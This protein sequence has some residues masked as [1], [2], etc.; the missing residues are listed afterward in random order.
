MV[1]L[2]ALAMGAFGADVRLRDVIYSADEVY[3]L[4]AYGG[5][6]ID[7]EFEAGEHFLGMG[8]GDLQGLSFRAQENHLFIK[9]R[10]V[11]VHTDITV[12]TDRRVY[13]F[14]YVSIG[15]TPDETHADLVYALRFLYPPAPRKQGVVGGHSVSGAAR[16]SVASESA[17]NSVVGNINY[18]FC[19]TPLLQP[20]AAWD[21]GMQTHLRFG[22]GQEIPVL[23][24]S[25][26]DGSES[27]VNF[28]VQGDEVVIHRL[29]HRLILR[30]GALRGCVVNKSYAVGTQAADAEKA[31]DVAHGARAHER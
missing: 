9:P 22:L 20:V 4:P 3:R 24:L 12:L 23:S 2:A 17:V 14:D 10:A 28:H 21:D 11:D 6:D 7:V 30:R 18:W 1:V 25:N 5:Y 8:T 31:A 16:S 27:L 19:G 29:V 15:S 13:H 26:D